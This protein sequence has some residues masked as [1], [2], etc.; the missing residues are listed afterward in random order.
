M[1]EV[2]ESWHSA[3]ALSFGGSSGPRL[4]FLGVPESLAS[5]IRRRLPSVGSFDC[6]FR[7]ARWSNLALIWK[8]DRSLVLMGSDWAYRIRNSRS[9]CSTTWPDRIT[10]LLLFNLP[11]VQVKLKDKNHTNW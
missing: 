4:V 1:V 9:K 7:S 5:L 10:K 11:S 6:G 8:L 2:S 3:L